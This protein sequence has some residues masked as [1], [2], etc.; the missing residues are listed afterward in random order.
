MSRHPT[1]PKRP[2]QADPNQVRNDDLI[3][4]TIIAHARALYGGAAE[5][6]V[7]LCGVDAWFEGDDVALRRFAGI[8]RKMTV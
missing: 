3:D 4:N 1:K 5:T 6:A 8:F 2:K 7:A